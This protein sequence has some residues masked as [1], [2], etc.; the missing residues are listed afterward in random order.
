MKGLT[1]IGQGRFV[2]GVPAI[3]LTAGQVAEIARRR[4]LTTN[5]LRS[6]LV[7]SGCY[8]EARQSSRIQPR[9]SDP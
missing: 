9:R 5:Q 1:Y 7:A 6:R 4:G 2:V 3:D 8:A